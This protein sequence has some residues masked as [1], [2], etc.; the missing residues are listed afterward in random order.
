MSNYPTHGVSPVG[1]RAGA[2]MVVQAALASA[3]QPVAAGLAD[4]LAAVACA[5]RRGSRYPICLVE[6]NRIVVPFALFPMVDIK[7]GGIGDGLAGAATRWFDVAE[8]RLDPRPDTVGVCGRL[9]CWATV[10]QRMAARVDFGGDRRR[11]L[12]AHR[13]SGS[14]RRMARP[15]RASAAATSVESGRSVHR[16]AARARTI[17][18]ATWHGGLTPPNQ[19]VDFTLRAGHVDRSRSRPAGLGRHA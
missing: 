9:W 15:R 3:V 17:R 6:S 2:A 16:S 12:T 7:C 11:R 4:G 14:R 8:E 10:D 5:R 19:G 13:R 1:L 18:S